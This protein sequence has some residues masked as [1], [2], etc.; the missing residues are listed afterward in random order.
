[1]PRYQVFRTQVVVTR[2]IVEAETAREA[3]AKSQRLDISK[4]KVSEGLIL[5]AEVRSLLDK[6]RIF[7]AGKRD[8]LGADLF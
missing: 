2:F 5:Y 8:N 6:D 1:M 7:I 4:G 3:E